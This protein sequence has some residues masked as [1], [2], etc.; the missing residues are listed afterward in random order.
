MKV[1]VRKYGG[2]S[3]SNLKRVH[4]VAGD[5]AHARASGSR[6]VVVVSAMGDT[7]D[8]LLGLVDEVTPAPPAREVD[9][10]LATGE[11]QSAALLAMAL[12]DMGVPAVSLDGAQAGIGVVG[13]HRAGVIEELDTARIAEQLTRNAVVV[14]AGFH[15]TNDTGDVVTLG[16]GG[17]DTTAVAVAAAL[18]ADRCEIFTDVPGICTAD[19]RVVPRARVLQVVTAAEMAEMAF[20]G[21]GV[22]HP[23][24]VELAA[25]YELDVHVGSSLDNRIGT[26]VRGG[27][28]KQLETRN[29][30]T[31]VVHDESSV[32]FHVNSPGGDGLCTVLD[33][34]S[35]SSAAADMLTMSDEAVSFTVGAD[36]ADGLREALTRAGLRVRAE[37]AIGK[38]SIVGTGLS[39]RP[40]VTSRLSR[41]LREAGVAVTH[42]WASQARASVIVPRDRTADAVNIVHDEFGL[43]VST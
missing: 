36:A 8:A 15:G 32:L 37:P 4:S 22:V 16:R 43:E 28:M 19:P 12:Q 3:L 34:L 2:S 5:V 40:D 33:E 11:R 27:R 31:A 42:A 10:L 20:A 24:A 35:A 7:T 41:C 29:V 13:D 6:V 9:T 1:T 18:A 38:V 17:S 14:V 30:V 23:R 21:A 26:V 39:S 25:L